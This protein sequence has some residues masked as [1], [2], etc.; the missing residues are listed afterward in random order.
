[1]I[2]LHEI[3]STMYCMCIELRHLKKGKKVERH[4]E[5]QKVRDG[6]KEKVASIQKFFS[7][8]EPWS[9]L[10]FSSGHMASTFFTVVFGLSVVYRSALLYHLYTRKTVL[11][12]FKKT[13]FPL[14]AGVALFWNDIMLIALMSAIVWLAARAITYLPSL[15]LSMLFSVVLSCILGCLLC[16]IVFIYFA[17]FDLM[18]SM[19]TGLSYEVI[20]ESVSGQGIMGVLDMVVWW[21]VI[22]LLLPSCIFWFLLWPNER[23]RVWRNG[24]VISCV[25]LCTLLQVVY[26]QSSASLAAEL[27]RNPV[28][29]ALTDVLKSYVNDHSS[30]KM[31]AKQSL[32]PIQGL[33]HPVA[34]NEKKVV[35]VF[36]P[37]KTHK[38]AKPNVS[39]NKPFGHSK[40]YTKLSSAQ[41]QSLQWIDPAFVGAPPDVLRS[42]RPRKN[43][44]VIVIV[45]ESTGAQ[46]VFDRSYGNDVPM[47]FLKKLSKQSWWLKNHFSPSNSSPRSVFSILS[48]LYPIPQLYFFSMWP[49]T[50]VPSF[51]SL[52]GDQY[53]SF[54]TN[55][56]PLRWYFPK[57]FL[58]N[59]GVDLFGYTA[60]PKMKRGPGKSPARDER[61]VTRFFIEKMR[62][63]KEP[64][65]GTMCTF[66]PHWP[67]P[68]YGKEYRVL[69]NPRNKFHRYYNGLR[70]VDTQIERVFKALKEQGKLERTIVV[71]AGDH[72]EAFGQHLGNWTHSRHSYNE[73]FRV[74]AL[75]YQPKLFKPKVFKRYTTH[76]DLM[77]TVLEGMGMP[78]NPRLLQGES[79]WK[80][81]FR[82]KYTFLYGNENTLS[83]ISK[84]GI[85]LQISFKTRRC[86]VYD[87]QRDPEETKRLHC[88]DFQEQMWA[89]L[90][91]RKYQTRVLLRYNR[92]RLKQR[93]F[94]GAE[95]PRL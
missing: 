63:A 50:S 56:S 40:I 11:F 58:K 42:K 39:S 81:E 77:P 3:K 2:F 94:H 4:I 29:F 82:R 21:Q 90:L 1:M 62:D 30:K 75:I 13:V 36:R 66:V 54:L 69:P 26:F 76:V 59:S 85:K 88:R 60:F 17:H 19:H 35:S 25:T 20:M 16:G 14:A 70:L 9:S 57:H 10:D 86:W 38:H 44:N 27:R 31:Y 55:P 33:I 51:A 64:F 7:R 34:K 93:S 48:G 15:R 87:L 68:D 61:E 67:Y 24:L 22:V 8:Q 91:Y 84:Q 18:L 53:D 12:G 72:G 23:V 78:Y 32:P 47:P 52:L 71:I 37:K 65:F 45:L 41:Y 46:Y 74:P 79:L 80:K 83:S 6:S 5:F 43:Y 49:K 73:N 89:T 92:S 28:T 95:H